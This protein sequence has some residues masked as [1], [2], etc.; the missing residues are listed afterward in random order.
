[1]TKTMIGHRII[2]NRQ[3]ELLAVQVI[4]TIE[5]MDF[6]LIRDG[7][8]LT[9]TLKHERMDHR[10]KQVIPDFKQ[11]SVKTRGNTGLKVKYAGGKTAVY[12]CGTK[13]DVI[14]TLMQYQRNVIMTLSQRITQLFD[15]LMDMKTSLSIQP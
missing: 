7:K 8:P 11:M 14:E 15:Q 4:Q 5:P 1:M 6:R 10:P 2:N 9:L 12:P 13:T 3:T